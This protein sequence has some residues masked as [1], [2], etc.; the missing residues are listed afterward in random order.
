LKFKYQKELFDIAIKLKQPFPIPL[1]SGSSIKNK[2]D[3]Q[4]LLKIYPNSET[5]K[6]IAD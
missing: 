2:S 6:N 4:E 1:E 5:L 3:A